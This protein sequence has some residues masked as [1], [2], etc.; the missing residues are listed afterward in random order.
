MKMCVKFPLV[1]PPN[2]NSPF[3]RRSCRLHRMPTLTTS[4]IWTCTCSTFF[5]ILRY[6]PSEKRVSA[7]KAQSTIRSRT[8]FVAQVL[9]RAN[10]SSCIPFIVHSVRIHHDK[11]FLL[12]CSSLPAACTSI[13]ACL[14]IQPSA[15]RQNPSFGGCDARQCISEGLHASGR[16]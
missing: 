16:L 1:E 5:S 10:Y 3:S 9:F 7:R 6:F 8:I 2:Q 11:S 12:L 13:G 4:P 15:T 14:S